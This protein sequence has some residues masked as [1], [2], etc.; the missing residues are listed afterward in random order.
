MK[1]KDLISFAGNILFNPEK[2]TR[3]NLSAKELFLYLLTVSLVASIIGGI[4]LSISFQIETKT[5]TIGQIL[6]GLVFDFIIPIRIPRYLFDIIL[7][8]LSFPFSIPLLFIFLFIRSFLRIIILGGGIHLIGKITKSFKKEFIYTFRSNAYAETPAILFGWLPIIGQ[9]SDFWTFIILIKSVSNQHQITIKKAF[10]VFIIATILIVILITLVFYISFKTVLLAIFPAF[11]SDFVLNEFALESNSPEPCWN[12]DFR[13]ADSCFQEVAINLRDASLCN[14]MLDNQ[15]YCRTIIEALTNKDASLCKEL[16]KTY[17]LG[18]FVQ[19]CYLTLATSMMNSS[20]CDLIEDVPFNRDII[21]LCHN[22]IKTK[23]AIENNNLALCEELNI[24]SPHE[25][26]KEKN[27]CYFSVAKA[28]KDTSLCEKIMSDDYKIYCRAILTADST[29]CKNINE[30]WY[31]FP[32]R[33]ECYED[34]AKIT[35]DAS[36]CENMYRDEYKQE[37]LMEVSLRK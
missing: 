34:I 5:I 7:K 18:T 37:C 6:F 20:I 23:L 14:N 17:K 29:L 4:F 22:T 31:A 26:D 16:E 11:D 24:T 27:D 10:S 32:S 35:L 15:I 19:R 13:N 9:L 8:A 12:I 2:A 30:M 28:K 3:E 1:L 33:N 21:I 25:R 36:L